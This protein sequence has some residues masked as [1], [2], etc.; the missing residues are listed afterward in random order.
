MKI[1][2]LTGGST[3]FIELMQAQITLSKYYKPTDLV[4]TSAS[5]I[6][7]IPFV[8]GMYNEI[9]EEG[10]N[11]D[12][13]EFMKVA[14][15]NGNGKLSLVGICR[16]IL[17]LL[18]FVKINSLGIQDVSKLLKKHVP[19]S[20]FKEYVNGDYPNVHVFYVD[21]TTKTPKIEN[22][23]NCT[24]QEYLDLVMVSAKIQ[25]FVKHGMFRGKEG[26]DGGMYLA[27]AVG[28]FMDSDEPYF[29]DV[30]QV[31]A[32]YVWD[33]PNPKPDDKWK[34]NFV[35]NAIGASNTLKAGGKWAFPRHEYWYCKANNIP[36]LQLFCPDLNESLYDLDNLKKNGEITKEK[37]QEQIDV[38]LDFFEEK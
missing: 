15:T 3:Q 25:P 11:L 26:V 5:A 33:N 6:G 35:E 22:L 27:G 12:M 7:A 8:L 29:K 30:E 10:E 36:L 9:I 18:P 32:I 34:K 37:I 19:P 28:Y 13:S 14:P 4:V 20:K 17:G 21:P 2:S 16:V 24:Y 23:K 31:A 38:R 1:L